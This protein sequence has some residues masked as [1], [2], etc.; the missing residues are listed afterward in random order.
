MKISIPITENNGLDSIVSEHFGRAPMHL[1]VDIETLATRTFQKANS[2]D[3]KDHGHC[4]P[5]DLL[6][7]NQV[8]IVACKGIGRGAVA[9]LRQHDISLF[10]TRA[11]TVKEVVIEF[12]SNLLRPVSNEQ[13]C[14]GHGDHD[15][16]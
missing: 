14:K 3:D 9:R 2:C 16:H 4:L 10:A 8:K 7:E 13:I 6:L 1:V 12:Q 15:H 11:T 5:V